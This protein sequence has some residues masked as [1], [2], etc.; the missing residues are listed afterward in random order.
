MNWR[1][2]GLL[3]GI[4]VAVAASGFV[5]EELR[6]WP[7]TNTDVSSRY[8]ARIE[9]V[10]LQEQMSVPLDPCHWF[11]LGYSRLE[12]VGAF[13]NLPTALLTGWHGA[14]L[15]RTA[16]GRVVR[17]VVGARNHRAEIA[18]CGCLSVL[19][20][21]QWMLVGEMSLGHRRRWWLEPG[22]FITAVTVM[23]VAVSLIPGALLLTRV[24]EVV[25]GLAWFWWCGLLIWKP[26]HWAWRSTLGGLRRLSN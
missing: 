21:I 8:G 26:V 7:Y 9:S 3:A 18:D 1:R 16:L 19:V 11:D 15:T 6:F 22:A 2:G 25:V 23:G 5:L 4:H 13:A 24:C 10:L 17:R 12:E 14:C 20:C